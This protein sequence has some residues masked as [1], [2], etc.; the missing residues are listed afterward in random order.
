MKL[1]LPVLLFV[2]VACASDPARK[3]GRVLEQNARPFD[4]SYTI[5]G[6]TLQVKDFNSDGLPDTLRKIYDSGSGFSGMDLRLTDGRSGQTFTVQ[7]DYCFCAFRALVYL[8]ADVTADENSAFLAAILEQFP[9]LRSQ[10][11]P[12]LRWVQYG[13][14]NE[15]LLQGNSQ[16]KRLIE[17]PKDWIE[18]EIQPPA[19][20]SLLVNPADWNMQPDEFEYAREQEAPGG[21]YLLVYRG[22]N[23][24]GPCGREKAPFSLA[25]QTADYKIWKTCHGLILEKAGR[26]KWIFLSDVSF[27]GAPSKLRHP[28]IGKTELAGQFLIFQQI[29]NV[30]ADDS[31]GAGPAI[32]LIDL[33]NDVCAETTVSTRV[34]P[35]SDPATI[36]QAFQAAQ[37]RK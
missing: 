37:Q 19:Q 13:I 30:F 28:S 29:R 25:E 33:E 22:R 10:P 18:G 26:H 31:P 2:A 5:D 14:K 35:L 8:P 12:S 27:T 4:T 16:L 7:E 17:Y 3:Q 11:D 6:G 23:H 34:F 20:Y 24:Y 1:L 21:K 9:P 36:L 32:W 15:R